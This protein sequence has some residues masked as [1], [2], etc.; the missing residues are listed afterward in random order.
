MA[1]SSDFPTG[2]D[3]ILVSQERWER[4]GD[5]IALNEE[6][7]PQELRQG[8]RRMATFGL[9]EL[10]ASFEAQCTALA[11][12]SRVQAQTSWVN[13]LGIELPWG[14]R[15]GLHAFLLHGLRNAFS[16]GLPEG[17]KALKLEFSATRWGGFARLELRDHG[18]GIDYAAI[19]SAAIRVGLLPESARGSLRPEQLT[20]LL[21]SQGFSSHSQAK[22][23]AGR[24]IGL[25]SIRS[26]WSAETQLFLI[27]AEGSGT[28]LRLELPI[29]SF[30]AW[31]TPAASGALTVY[32]VAPE[33]E[34]EFRVFRRLEE[35]FRAS[36]STELATWLKANPVAFGS[37][38]G[39]RLG[40]LSWG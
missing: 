34:G 32:R 23:L 39:G 13:E 4:L 30:G 20:E 38:A 31:V 21:L 19:E 10:R 28:I 25:A 16:H 29:E 24:G 5:W 36:A 15:N 37:I 9:D 3:S 1:D 22:N 8:F 35:S 27:P 26:S 7:V 18:R 11:A 14:M 17:K 40:V 33:G 6:S 2:P 12:T